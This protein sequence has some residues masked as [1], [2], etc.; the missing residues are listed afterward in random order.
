MAEHKEKGKT[1][2]KEEKK[3]AEA[4]VASKS[5]LSRLEQQRN[6][7]QAMLAEHFKTK[8]SI[9]DPSVGKYHNHG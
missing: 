4:I 5:E 6:D 7:Q 9:S 1:I 3:M 2:D 8:V